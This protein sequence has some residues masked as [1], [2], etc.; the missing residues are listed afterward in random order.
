MYDGIFLDHFA[1]T[2]DAIEC[3]CS[4]DLFVSFRGVSD[5]LWRALLQRKYSCYPRIKS[6]LP[7][8]PD[9]QLQRNW[10]GNC[11][12]PLDHQS[13][14]F[15]RNLKSAYLRYGSKQ[16]SHSTVLDFG[17]GWGRLIRYLAKDV[18]AEHLWGC[19]SDTEILAICERTRVPGV[20]RQSAVRPVDLPFDGKADLA[21]AFSVLTH[22]SERTHKE[23][24][25]CLHQ[26]LSSDG[27]LV[28]TVRP[29]AFLATMGLLEADY[30]K[31]YLFAPHN[32][33]PVDGDVSFGD[34]VIADSYI[35]SHWTTIFHILDRWWLPEDSMQVAYVLQKISHA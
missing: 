24:L 7:D 30:R 19:D 31:G 5:E 9:E 8:W 32:V 1:D 18:P 20:L 29:R 13:F 21:Y 6:F 28:V 17:V 11:G 33:P 22:L 26:S 27:I 25:K 3:A 34:A 16:L 10:V 35:R 14:G 23:V 15:I 12:E 2:L 4:E